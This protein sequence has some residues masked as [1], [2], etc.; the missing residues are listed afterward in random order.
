MRFAAI[1][2]ATGFVGTLF[3]ANVQGS[4]WTDR[5]QAAGLFTMDPVD[6]DP[7]ETG[8]IGTAGGSEAMRLIDLRSGKVCRTERAA[9]A[10]ATFVEAPLGEDCRQS[11]ALSRVAF[12][13]AAADGTLI[14]ADRGGGTVIA[15][16]PGDGVLYESIYPLDALIT[17]V[18]ARS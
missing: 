16:A 7:I 5:A 1:A 10:T 18:P 4:P 15:F 14:L 3:A 6:I 13:R 9:P 8:G 2:L 17:I 12:W 11:P